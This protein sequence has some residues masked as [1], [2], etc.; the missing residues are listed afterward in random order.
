MSRTQQEENKR[1]HAPVVQ[2]EINQRVGRTRAD[3]TLPPSE[4]TSAPTS[5]PLDLLHGHRPRL[6]SAWECRRPPA[7]SVLTAFLLAAQVAPRLRHRAASEE[8]D[9]RSFR[10]SSRVLRPDQAPNRA[11]NASRCKE[12]IGAE[13]PRPPR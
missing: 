6:E 1:S 9:D 2:P 13:E 8:V 11:S 7:F 4:R 10:P 3:P 5:R 12:R